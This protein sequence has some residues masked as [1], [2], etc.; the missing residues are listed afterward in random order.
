MSE[1]TQ[2]SEEVAHFLCHHAKAER[3]PMTVLANRLVVEALGK[4]KWIN[5]PTV[6]RIST[7]QNRSSNISVTK[8]STSRARLFGVAFFL[9]P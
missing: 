9:K 5:R 4:K 8:N 2:L 6:A 1:G 3:I 7:Y